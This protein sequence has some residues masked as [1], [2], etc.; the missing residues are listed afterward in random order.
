MS[1]TFSRTSS[2]SWFSRIGSSFM[3][4]L[5]GLALVPGAI[6]LLFWNE[7]E[8]VKQA[9]ALREG[10]ANVQEVGAE[11]I[12]PAHEGQLIHISGMATTQEVLRDNLFQIEQAAIKLQRHVEMYQWTEREKK[13]T[14]QKLG[15]GEQTI[16]TYTYNLE[17][18]DGRIDSN[19]F[20]Q[21]AG[22]ENPSP[23]YSNADFT[24]SD[25]HVGA[26]PLNKGLLEK[27]NQFSAIELSQTDWEKFDP[28][29]RAE[30]K[31]HD[32]K[33]F[34]RKSGELAPTPEKST[35][36]T[37]AV[38]P[39]T[40]SGEVE[41]GNKNVERE[42]IDTKKSDTEKKNLEKSSTETSNPETSNPETSNPETSNSG[43]GSTEQADN[44]NADTE[45]DD[46]KQAGLSAHGPDPQKPELGDLRIRLE[47]V[48]PSEVSIISKQVGQRL[49]PYMTSNKREIELLSYGIVSAELMFERAQQQLAF[50]TWMFRGF[51]FV[52]MGVGIM[53]ILSPLSVM[54]DVIPILGKIASTGIFIIA[55][56]SAAVLS[57]LTISLAW[58][59]YRPLLGIGLL[60]AAVIIGWLLWKVISR[61]RKQPEIIDLP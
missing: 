55:F 61:N 16:T 43:K 44:E 58:L 7:G 15:G 45:I 3:G 38:T 22:H 37:E 51:G 33:I 52:L 39:D 59:F 6:A 10:A 34:W 18:A 11:K 27:M 32:G 35:K 56:L 30:T 50:K 14:K 49:E 57:L 20:A 5:I 21:P 8:A 54:L 53:L 41:T 28:Q 40:T 42:A 24:A 13:E 46:A 19:D 17:W 23:K 31:I 2:R 36:Q 4:I 60:V 47:A 48:Q 25:V 26:F 1:N 29:L 12:D 9:K